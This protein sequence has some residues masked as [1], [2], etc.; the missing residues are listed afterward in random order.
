[1]IV[2]ALCAAR[3]SLYVDRS[4]A[5]ESG[6]ATQ[7]TSVRYG[8]FERA[9]GRPTKPETQSTRSVPVAPAHG[10]GGDGGMHIA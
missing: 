4:E 7:C 8:V 6:G 1:M 2:Y 3:A 10:H 9:R 5:T